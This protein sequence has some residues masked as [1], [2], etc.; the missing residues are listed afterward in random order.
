[1]REGAEVVASLMAQ[2]QCL[3]QWRLIEFAW[4]GKPRFAI[5]NDDSGEAVCEVRDR[6]TANF[7]ISACNIHEERLSLVGHA[8]DGG[9]E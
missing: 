3:R 7:I 1:M 8:V 4:D 9:P 6:A 2:N 5:L